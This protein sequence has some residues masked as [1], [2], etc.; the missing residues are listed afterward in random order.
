MSKKVPHNSRRKRENEGESF[1]SDLNGLKAPNYCFHVIT[2]MG[3]SVK[4]CDMSHLISTESERQGERFLAKY[5]FKVAVLLASS[6]KD[7]NVQILTV[8]DIVVRL[9]S[10]LEFFSI[11]L[12][13]YLEFFSKYTG[14]VNG[15]EGS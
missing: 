3:L 14:E 1:T 8:N 15:K 12:V 5:S 7:A 13:Y 9:F 6:G 2:E 11:F 10:I 4:S